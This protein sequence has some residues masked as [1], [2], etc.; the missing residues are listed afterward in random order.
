MRILAV[1]GSLGAGKSTFVETTVLWGVQ[2][3]TLGHQRA[4][5][6]LNDRPSSDGRMV[7]GDKI[8]NVARVIPFPNRCFTCED[9]E[10]L[11]R[12]LRTL[13]DEGGTDLVV[14]EGYGFVAGAETREALEM[15]GFPFDIF[16][17]VDAAHLTENRAAYG[18]VIESQIASA[19]LGIGITHIADA[20]DAAFD[21]IERHAHSGVPSLAIPK[22]RGMPLHLFKR[23]LF[24]DGHHHGACCCGH[25]HDHHHHDHTHAEHSNH[26]A[27]HGHEHGHDHEHPTHDFFSVTYS[28]HAGVSMEDLRV[29]LAS[30]PVFRAK[31][32]ANGVHFDM[33]H[34]DWSEGDRV[35]QFGII[36]LYSRG[37]EILIPESFIDHEARSDSDHRSTKELLRHDVDPGAA[38][39]ALERL[40]SAIPAEP[41]VLPGENG[42]H[43][44]VQPEESQHLKQI[45]QRPSVQAEWLPK[46]L[47]AVTCYKIK[48]AD[49][50]ALHEKEIDKTELSI[51]QLE[52]AQALGWWAAKHPE[53]LG[54][55]LLDEV[56]RCRV[57]ELLVKGVTSSHSPWRPHSN[58]EQ[59]VIQAEEFA[60]IA[61]FAIRN[62]EEPAR[63]LQA[64]QVGVTYTSVRSPAVAQAWRSAMAS[65]VQ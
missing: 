61:R 65:S 54:Q 3:G 9:A 50:I 12:Q 41:V 63:V 55:Y 44:I 26:H 45:A 56:V 37:R 31:G 23:A 60:D 28:L 36:T 16:S 49:F 4:A 2:S 18:E 51:I 15:T 48:C 13:A 59:A 39:A 62:G 19:T 47:V 38:R 33:L 1:V 58:N 14:I 52:L 46:A 5:Y 32:V 43:V 27:H 7:D 29:A 42:L 57:G 11:A 10:N 24:G 25:D 40:A 21:I 34:G 30:E 20:T 22:D 35:G 53:L 6:L 64:L 8:K 17:L